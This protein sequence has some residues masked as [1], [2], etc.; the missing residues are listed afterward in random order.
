MNPR[1]ILLLLVL[2][3]A[4][5]CA[6]Q[7]TLPAAGSVAAPVSNP[8]VPSSATVARTQAPVASSP[9][10]AP[11]TKMQAVLVPSEVVVGQNR[12][13]VGLMDASGELIHDASVH[14]QYYDLT[15]PS[16]PT[17][18]SQADAVR[19]ETPDGLTTI[20]SHERSFNR[21]GKWGVVVQARL[22]DGSSSAASIGF[23]VIADSPTL[24]IGQ[25]VP[26][27]KT[28]TAA[29]VDNNLKALTSAAQPNPAFYQT[30]LSQAI[31]NGKPT[32]LLLSTPAF[33]VSRLCG[34]AY[35]TTSALQSRYGDKLNF[36][37]AEVYTGLP[38]PAATNF[39]LSPIMSAL[40]LKTE[41]WLFLIDKDGA[42]AYR[43]EGLFT[44]D[45]VDGHIQALLK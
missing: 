23:E 30:S 38:N 22:P 39:Q 12:F 26:S 29:D 32:V 37:S 40:G 28:Q 16:S 7:P 44:T 33:C 41:P 11:A 19:V 18:E 35:D 24:K 20:F 9:A 17:L 25:K 3:G 43:F 27:I 4:T 14:F 34:P 2:A 45:E 8:T 36:V 31:T 42:V 21:V 15:N 10:Q 13:A 1:S 5:A 6:S